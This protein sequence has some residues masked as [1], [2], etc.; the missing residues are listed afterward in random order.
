V[1]EMMQVEINGQK[2]KV[3]RECLK[4]LQTCPEGVFANYPKERPAPGKKA[5][6]WIMVPSMVSVGTGCK[7]CEEVCPEKAVAVS[8]AA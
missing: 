5:V 6:D 3:P 7:I 2:C 1:I 4:C 8:V